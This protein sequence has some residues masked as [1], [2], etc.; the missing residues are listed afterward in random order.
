MLALANQTLD[1]YRAPLDTLGLTVT[2]TE[3]A[4]WGQYGLGDR[5]KVI[6]P[7]YDFD[8]YE[9]TCRVISRQYVPDNGF[10]E[11][12]VEGV[13]DISD[14]TLA[15]EVENYYIEEEGT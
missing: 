15:Q 2:N 12:V 3:P 10:C 9:A 8:G 6:L 1:N 7:N 4:K 13:Q 14:D 11:L 5:L